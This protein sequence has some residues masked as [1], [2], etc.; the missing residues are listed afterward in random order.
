MKP[1]IILA[2]FNSVILAY[3]VVRLEIL[4]RAI[5]SIRGMIGPFKGMPSYRVSGVKAS[6]IQADK[7]L[8]DDSVIH[9]TDERDKILLGDEV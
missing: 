9:L 5:R 1:E 2:V 6:E 8:K 3:V 4:Q 7:G